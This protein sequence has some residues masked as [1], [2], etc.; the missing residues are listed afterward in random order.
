MSEP[1]PPQHYQEIFDRLGFA[2]LADARLESCG[3][4]RA[5]VSLIPRPEV[6]QVNGY[7]HGGC[8]ALL[9]DLAGGMASFSLI[10]ND[11]MILSNTMTIHFIRP[12]AGDLLIAE[13]SVVKHGKRLSL[14]ETH[15]YARQAGARILVAQ[16][17]MSSSILDRA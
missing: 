7:V 2:R 9:S 16:G 3:E 1:I 17:T 13:G 12:A 8:L 6:S 10:Q 15:I 4:G 5:V 11:Q 14:S